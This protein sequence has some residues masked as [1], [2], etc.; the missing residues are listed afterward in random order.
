MGCTLSE[1]KIEKAIEFHGHTCPGLAIGI[2]VSELAINRIGIDQTASGLCVV[3]TDM[4]AVDA[5][6]FLTG[7]TFGKGNLVHRDWGKAG[8]TFFNRDTQKGFRALFNN[9]F[10]RN[11]E[12]EDPDNNTGK[13]MQKVADKTAT[14]DEVQQAEDMK[15]AAIARIM[16][17][18]LDDLFLVEEIKA[19]PVKPARI[20]ASIQCQSCS[21]MVMESRMR[22]FDG[23]DLCIPCFTKKEQKV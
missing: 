3:E 2:R 8:F 23:Q 5:V 4:C 22:R 19:P 15:A 13:L 10:R 16:D 6:Q 9:D 11:D 21:E 18:D 17:A 1:E 14:R 20:L 12:K 7:C